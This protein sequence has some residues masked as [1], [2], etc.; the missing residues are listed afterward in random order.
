MWPRV[1]AQDAGS[2]NRRTLLG[3]CDEAKATRAA[4]EIRQR[5]LA[6]VPRHACLPREPP[7]QPHEP[8]HQRTFRRCFA[9]WGGFG[10]S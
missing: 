1:A 4:S 3:S 7:P 10:H 9:R 8:S 6:D 2:K 5:R